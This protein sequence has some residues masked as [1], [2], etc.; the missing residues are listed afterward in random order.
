MS[1]PW[2]AEPTIQAALLAQLR[3][4]AP[5]VRER[6][7]RSLE[8]AMSEGAVASAL[9]AMLNDPVR[10]V[11]VAAAWVMRATV[12]MQGHAGRD[13]QTML[14][15]EADQP[16]GQFEQAMLLLSRHH[17]DQALVHLKKA[18]SWDPLSPPFLCAQAQVQDQLGQLPE[19]LKTL[20]QGAAAVPDDPHVPCARAT[21]FARNGRYEEARASANRALAMQADFQPALA[22]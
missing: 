9:K 16:T 5:L 12:D 7:V 14:D 21:I 18:T 11:R 4:E 15:L 20:D 1:K 22:L 6:V 19:A 17:P 8:P 13:L 2:A 3:N 10:N